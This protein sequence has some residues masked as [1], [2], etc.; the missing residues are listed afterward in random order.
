MQQ[1]LPPRRADWSATE[2]A[3]EE[4]ALVAQFIEAHERCD[5]E[6]V[7]AIAA[8][9]IRVALDRYAEGL[10]LL[11]SY[12]REQE[13]TAPHALDSSHTCCKTVCG[14]RALWGE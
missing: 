8:K 9:D 14:F 7:I 2:L 11:C 5:Y 13:P 10:D 12:V 3:A 4:R 1:H 6:A